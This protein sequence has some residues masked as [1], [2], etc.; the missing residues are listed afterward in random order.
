MALRATALCFKTVR[1]NFQQ[2]WFHAH[3]HAAHLPGYILT[4]DILQHPWPCACLNCLITHF[5]CFKTVRDIL[6]WVWKHVHCFVAHLPGYI[7]TRDIFQHLWDAVHCLSTH[8]PRL[9]LIWE[10]FRRPWIFL[11]CLITH[12]MCFKMVRDPFYPVQQGSAHPL[13]DIPKCILKQDNL[14]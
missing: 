14:S 7:L 12:F 13:D 5:L 8:P 4:R 10:T 11:D 6:E 1:N 9:I 3:Y 2:P